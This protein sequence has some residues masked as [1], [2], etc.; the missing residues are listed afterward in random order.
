MDDALLPSTADELFL[1][2]PRLRI[3]VLGKSGAGKTTLIQ[4]AFGV[5]NLEGSNFVP[6]RCNIDEEITSTQNARFC[7]HD[8]QGFEPGEQNNVEVVKRFIIQR[9]EKEHIRDKIHAIWH[10]IPVPVAGGRLFEV[11]DEE[12]LSSQTSLDAI[13]DIPIIVVFTQY[14]RLYDLIEFNGETA[15]QTGDN[16]DGAA[17]EERTSAQFQKRC[18]DP[19]RKLNPRLPWAKVSNHKRYRDTYATLVNLTT[20]LI[21]DHVA[22]MAWL[23]SAAAQRVDVDLKVQ[24]SIEIGMRKYW[25]KLASNANHFSG[26]NLRQCLEMIQRDMIRTWNFRDSELVLS[27]NEFEALTIQIIQDLAFTEASPNLKALYGLPT[28]KTALDA[29][30]VTSLANIS[31]AGV[32][33][34]LTQWLFGAYQINAITLRS[35]M[36]FII[37]LTLVLERLFW[38]MYRQDIGDVTINEIHQA[39]LAYLSSTGKQAA[40]HADIRAYVDRL[41]F[42]N[43]SNHDDTHTE[44]RRLI[45]AHRFAPK[46]KE[47][48]SYPPERGIT[49]GCIRLPGCRIL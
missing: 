28:I 24:A 43:L 27:G 40:V 33:T 32:P 41:D 47:S 17:L 39:A 1:E 9:S 45:E 49:C 13:R 7:L 37:D 42:R 20:S 11:G 3:L 19:L 26:K 30:P 18:S 46:L 35:I 14:D 16:I 23:V 36:G 25:R 34:E 4:R 38:N 31:V 8:S 6:G 5:D 12:F 2:C 29:I 22:K 44:I 15:V 21:R 48:I 10:C